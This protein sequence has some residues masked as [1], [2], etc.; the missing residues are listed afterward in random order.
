MLGNLRG[1]LISAILGAG[2]LWM[3]YMVAATPP[4][5]A[6]THLPKFAV[7]RKAVAFPTSPD[8]FVKPGV[9]DCD[10]ADNYRKVIEDFQ[11]NRGMYED[12]GT[13]VMTIREKDLPAVQFILDARDCSKCKLF[14]K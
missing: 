7:A 8:T 5:T 4:L 13:K 3:L 6:P 9:K 14:S 2:M 12:F 1:W 10:A 11:I